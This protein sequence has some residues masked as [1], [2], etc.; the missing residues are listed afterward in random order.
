MSNKHGCRLGEGPSHLVNKQEYQCCVGQ[1]SLQCGVPLEYM[2]ELG[3]IRSVFKKHPEY[4]INLMPL[5]DE[6]IAAPIQLHESLYHV[7]DDNEP[8]TEQRTVPEKIA[9]IRRL[10]E[11]A[12]HTLV[13]VNEHYIRTT[14]AENN[15]E[16]SRTPG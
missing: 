4:R 9:E 11:L 8:N 2:F 6:T 12:G 13:V 10:L 1:F 3:T 5:L 14:D 16:S 15:F 7:N